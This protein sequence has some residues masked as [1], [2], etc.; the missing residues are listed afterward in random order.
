M[1]TEIKI[2]RATMNTQD[3]V[4]LCL[5]LPFESRQPARDFV[6]GM[7]EDKR[8]TAVLK[9]KKASRTLDQNAYYWV[10]CGKLSGKLKIPPMEIYREH[11]Q[12]VGDNFEVVPIK[13][14]RVDKWCEA[15][16]R[17]GDGFVTAVMGESR[18]TGYTNVRSYYGSSTYDTTQMSRLLDLII[19]DCKDNDIP[20]ATPEEIARMGGA[21]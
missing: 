6:L 21:T 8:Y 7:A 18:L 5:K 1:S 9:E 17:N 13:T 20:T 10:L 15:W 16:Q 4:W 19:Q 2:E 12:D 14:E 11:I 3:G